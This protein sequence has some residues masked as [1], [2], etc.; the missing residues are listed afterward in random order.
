MLMPLILRLNILQDN[1]RYQLE[2][3]FSSKYTGLTANLE[4]YPNPEEFNPDNFQPETAREKYSYGY[5]PFSAGPRNC[6]GMLHIRLGMW[7]IQNVILGS[8]KE[9]L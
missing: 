6:I 5:I 2:L 4:C 3:P 1:T 9:F 7:I 8:Q